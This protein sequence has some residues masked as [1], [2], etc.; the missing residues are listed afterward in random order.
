[1]YAPTAHTRNDLFVIHGDF[2]HVVDVDAGID[3]GLRLGDG[4]RET[5]EEEAAGAVGLG[6]TFLDEAD[7]DVVRDQPTGIHDRL[8]L[9]AQL[10]AGLDR[11]T[12]HVSRR[13]LRE[14]QRP[15]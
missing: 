2:D 14:C 15:R 8:R 7:D 3:H 9:P 12:E 5:I 6:D 13:D 1:M 4:A 10:R 11:R